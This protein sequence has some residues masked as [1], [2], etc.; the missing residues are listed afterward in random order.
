MIFKA[1]GTYIYRWALK[2]QVTLHL[3]YNFGRLVEISLLSV[4]KCPSFR[5][6]QL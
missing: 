6:F 2:G 4:Q 5:T 1:G 3:I